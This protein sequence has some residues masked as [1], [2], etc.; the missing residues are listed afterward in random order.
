MAIGRALMKDAALCFA[1]EPTAALDWANGEKV[2]QMLDRA[3]RQ[4]GAAVFV[5]A[6]DARVV[7]FA[8]RVFYMEDGLVTEEPA[9]AGVHPR[10]V[11]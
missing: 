10:G 2:V 5:V 3:A 7:P 11:P 8:D 6:H 1:D 4:R 9:A